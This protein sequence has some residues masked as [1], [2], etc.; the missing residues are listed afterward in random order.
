MKL[1]GGTLAIRAGSVDR[2]TNPPTVDPQYLWYGIQSNILEFL[3]TVPADRQIRLRGEDV[4]NEPQLYFEK[5]C[6]WLN[7]AWDESVFQAMLRPQDSPYACLGPYR[8]SLGNDPNFLKSPTYR[9][10]SI[11][12]STLEG[13]LP[14]RADRKG[15]LS[16]V[17]QLARELGYE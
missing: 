14:W 5:V 13:A 7:L 1:A 3:K 16:P 10:R 8:A 12:P 6:R 9:Y 2:S 15:F 4:L 11:A 17:I